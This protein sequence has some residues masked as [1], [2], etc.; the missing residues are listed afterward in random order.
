MFRL[1][2]GE[3]ILPYSVFSMG[4]RCNSGDEEV[5]SALLRG[6]SQ[7]IV[8]G[9][10]NDT[11][12]HRLAP[13]PQHLFEVD[14]ELTQKFKLRHLPA[15]VVNRDVV[16]LPVNFEDE[17]WLERLRATGGEGVLQRKTLIIW[18]GVSYY[19]SAAA[20]RQTLSCVAA[21]PAG[22]RLIFDVCNPNPKQLAKINRVF[23]FLF[24]EPWLSVFNEDSLRSLLSEHGLRLEGAEGEGLT[25][26]ANWARHSSDPAFEGKV[27]IPRPD[28]PAEDSLQRPFLLAAAVVLE[29][30]QEMEGGKQTNG[31]SPSN[32]GAKSGP[33]ELI[34]SDDNSEV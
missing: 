14:A 33:W 28:M 34:N 11:R 15:E 4:G 31:G 8:L 6:F 1:L 22:S 24:G 27:R 21:F 18:D 12:L 16:F 7:I 23:T 10:G 13:L 29:K 26:A 3:Y 30:D 25:D 20:I 5:R 2:F 32:Q 17:S 19:L 9:A